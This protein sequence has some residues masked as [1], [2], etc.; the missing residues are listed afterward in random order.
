EAVG[1]V[2]FG[3][4]GVESAI[5]EQAVRFAGAGQEKG[6]WLCA[7]RRPGGGA[8]P[9]VQTHGEVT[10]LWILGQD[11]VLLTFE[12]VIEPAVGEGIVIE[13]G[14]AHAAF[15]DDRVF[16]G[17]FVGTMECRGDN[18]VLLIRDFGPRG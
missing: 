8:L 9:F 6:L 2:C 7:L 1:V 14:I 16:S 17:A 4:C 12:E 18:G 11:V 13:A 3:G 10:H 15:A 5:T